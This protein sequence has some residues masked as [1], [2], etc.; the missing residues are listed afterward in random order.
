MVQAKSGIDSSHI[1]AKIRPQDDLYRHFNG[2]WLA[3][4]QI[5][6]DRASDG[7][8][9]ALHDE[10]ERQ[11]RQIIESAS[12]DG[13][14]QKI[15]DLYKSFMDTA[16]IES[17]GTS[18]L[19]KDLAEIDAI[20]DLAGFVS[21]M[22]ALEIRGLGGIFGAAIYTDAMDSNTNIVYLGQGGV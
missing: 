11:V 19:N 20:K 9:Y 18:P 21:K 1:D 6:N 10:A 8:A 13:D 22:S 12:G 7:V 16:S 17:L 14:A 3:T 2:K 5:P 15:G 4:H